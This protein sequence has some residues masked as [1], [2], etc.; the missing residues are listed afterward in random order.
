MPGTVTVLSDES[1]S[2]EAAGLTDLDT[3]NDEE[4]GGFLSR[5]LS[6]AESLVGAPASASIDASV[7][8]FSGGSTGAAYVNHV[9]Q[10][11]GNSAGDRVVYC[12]EID[13]HFE[14]GVHTR[15]DLVGNSLQGHVV[16]EA[17]AL[18]TGIMQHYFFYVSGIET[19]TARALTQRA[20]SLFQEDRNSCCPIRS[21]LFISFP[22]LLSRHSNRLS[23]R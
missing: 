20:V 17:E 2:D 13:M 6:F 16:T 21:A 14:A 23:K 8:C 9:Y 12:G 15:Q 18:N 10:T 11:S 4:K 7:D 1:L 5:I 22:P 19:E 3:E